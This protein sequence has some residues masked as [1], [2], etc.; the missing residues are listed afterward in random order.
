MHGCEGGGAGRGRS[1]Q[2]A[3]RA[4]TLAKVPSCYSSRLQGITRPVPTPSFH[5]QTSVKYSHRRAVSDALRQTSGAVPHHDQRPSAAHC[6]L[7]L[8]DAAPAVLVGAGCPGGDAAHRPRGTLRSPRGLHWQMVP[9]LK[10][11]SSGCGCRTRTS[12]QAIPGR[13]CFEVGLFLC[14]V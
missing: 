6:L 3:I 10:N 2:T 14:N 7:L 1:R 11:R 5:A 4:I 9:R 8:T 12:T 13:A